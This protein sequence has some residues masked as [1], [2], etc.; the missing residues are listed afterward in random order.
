MSAFLNL[1]AWN[2]ILA[3][4]FDGFEVQND[5]SPAWLVNP[6]TH[7]RLKLDLL[8]PEI[9]VAVRFV[10][11]QAK[12]QGRKSEWE[13]LEDSSRDEVR[14]ELCRVN[15]VELILI[16]PHDAFPAE[17]FKEIGMVLS[18]TSRRLAQGRRFQAKAALLERLSQSRRTA[19]DIRRRIHKLE[20]LI[21]YADLWRD[22]EARLVMAVQTEAAATNGSSK[23]SRSL[24]SFR[25]GQEVQHE[26]YGPGVITQIEERPD[27]R[28]LDGAVRD[29][30]RAQ[31]HGFPGGRQASAGLTNSG[32]RIPR[33]RPEDRYRPRQA[34]RKGLGPSCQ[35][36]DRR[37][38]DTTTSTAKAMI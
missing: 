4:I 6:G 34:P 25:V 37:P 19:D 11:L 38:A 13:E 5:T 7:R 29:F 24:P 27:D 30:R 18:A 9:G 14:K 20:D 10:G 3:R 21:P 28:Y 12:G 22:R 35:R 36:T 17:Q 23:R 16:A 2:E 15:G 8:Y 32:S 31:V 1:M 26:R 33:S